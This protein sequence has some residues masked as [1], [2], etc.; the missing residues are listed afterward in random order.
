LRARVGAHEACPYAAGS[1][2]RCQ[3]TTHTPLSVSLATYHEPCHGKFKYRP[4][5]IKGGVSRDRV[6]FFDLPL[7]V[8]GADDAHTKGAGIT[9]MKLDTRGLGPAWNLEQCC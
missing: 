6:W 4:W 2:G 5:G 3:T 8:S 1:Q 7:P 9:W